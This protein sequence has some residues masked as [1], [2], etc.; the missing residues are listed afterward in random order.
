MPTVSTP[1][2][3][4]PDVRAGVER[5]L[6]DDETLIWLGTPRADLLGRVTPGELVIG[7]TMFV[8]GVA[9]LVMSLLIL[10]A[11]QNISAAA[12]VVF[13]LIAVPFVLLGA[14]ILTGPRRRRRLSRRTAYMLTDRRAVGIV[15]TG[16]GEA[17]VRHW[18][19][20]ALDTMQ[21]T[22]HA[23]GSGDLYFEPPGERPEDPARAT[24]RDPRRGFMCIDEVAT[25]ER[26]VRDAL[27]PP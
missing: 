11:R 1:L 6:R 26:L 9:W 16:R 13:P 2:D 22:E 5:E 18:S 20:S 25:V 10:Q 19:G 12:S 21:R 15:V 27:T 17:D 4:A 8:V 23:D 24:Q 3:L 7:M 14:L